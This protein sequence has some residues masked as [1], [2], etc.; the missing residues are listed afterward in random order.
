MRSRFVTDP[1]DP[2][3]GFVSTAGAEVY[4]I[5]QP[6]AGNGGASAPVEIHLTPA[7][8]SEAVESSSAQ[9]GPTTLVALRSGGIIF[10]LLFDAHAMAP[11]AGFG[12]G[13]RAGASF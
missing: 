5:F 13:L 6:S 4:T 3:D 12:L 1:Q 11:P 7:L 10:N 2:A 8:T 9:G